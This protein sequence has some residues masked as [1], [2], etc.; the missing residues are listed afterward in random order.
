MTH[1]TKPFL[2]RLRSLFHGDQLDRDLDDELA[3]HVA[4]RTQ[5]N[6][7]A[8]MNAAD[9]RHFAH[10]QLG[11]ATSIKEETRGLRT[12]PIVENLAQDVRYGSRT[13]LKTPLFALIAI[14]T[15]SLGIGASTAI[16][17]V[18][19][20][21]L[22]RP[23]PYAQPE[24]LVQVWELNLKAGYN[25]NVVAPMNFLDWTEQNRSFTGMAAVVD[26]STKLGLGQ[27]P[28]QVPAMLVS[29]QF[30]S[31]LGVAPL[32]GTTFADGDGKEGAEIHLV[33]RYEFWQ[34]QFGGDASVVGR[35][36][37]VNERSGTIIG[38]MPRGFG[39]PN[40][41]GSVFLP[42]AI[43]RNPEFA[44]T[45]R[46]MMVVARLKPD[47]TLQQANEDM[48]R[49]AGYT[50]AARPNFDTNWGAVVLPMLQDATRD[51]QQ[52]LLL[53]LGAVGFVLLIACANVANLLLMRGTGR[54]RELAVR[55][56]LGAARGRVV[57]QLLAENLVLAILGTL[58]GLA[59]A[60]WGLRGLL[61]LIPEAAPLPRMESIG[62]DTTV[63]LFALGLTFSTT[64]LFGLLP[65]LRL[66]HI[67]LLDALR[68]GTSRT[69]VGGNRRVRQALMVAEI[70]LALMLSVGAGLLLRSFQRLTSVNLG[71]RTD[72]LV[73]MRVFVKDNVAKASKRSQYLEALINAVRGV[74]GVQ[75]A[76]FTEFLPLTDR[77]SGSCFALGAELPKN[78]AAAPDAQ[79]LVVSSQYFDV[80]RTPFLAG[81]DF[82]E[83]DN[84]DAPTSVIVNQAFVRKFLPGKDA[85]G[86]QLS[87]CWTVNNPARIVGVVG[88]ARQ[89][90][91]KD[92]PAA[93]IFLPNLQAAAYA[94]TLVIRTAG[95]PSRIIRS[96]EMAIHGYD[97]Q[98]AVSEVQTM[99]HVFSDSAADARFQLVLLLIFA[100]L[101]VVLAM[102]G[103]YGVVSYSVTQRTQE[104][105]VRMAMGADASQIARLVLREALLFSGLAVALGLAG[106]IVLTRV[107]E[108]LLYETAPND[109][110]T[111]AISAAAIL[112][113]AG[114]AALVPARRAT[115][116][117]PLVALRYE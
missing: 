117:D 75:A 20:S 86:R 108:S 42:Y 40:V 16:F 77:V 12:L 104:I 30:F 1:W 112:L 89:T 24:R 46:Y 70:A 65:A 92:D 59:I 115:R 53:M 27:E 22:L 51:V 5:N 45:G 94:V 61:T 17:S 29:P 7:D 32:L 13:L 19:N 79:F 18:V 62:I 67:D 9:A 60:Q 98:Q 109:P 23:L 38:V 36:I 95:D 93:T 102:I 50:V 69:G 114:A 78:E 6:R 28:L 90:R 91:L 52:P 49:V 110:A 2:A 8:G 3:F 99:E 107:M 25:R 15:L 73:T 100:G 47:V 64:L 58:G 76:G 68:Q 105:G 96:A 72:N 101:A 84:A 106:A 74:H 116:V 39:L 4:Q 26:S 87:V 48:Q 57:C 56:A 34:Q 11:N 55:V 41:R 37:Q 54:E 21:V 82:N 33:L 63:F 80:M 31:V 85:I 103:V 43:T 66:S 10:R 81:R 14:V 71:F 35:H 113:I 88:D 83:H 111:L 44:S 97:P